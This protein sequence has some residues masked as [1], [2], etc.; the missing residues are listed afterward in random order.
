M[1]AFGLLFMVVTIIALVIDYGHK[2]VVH[3]TLDGQVLYVEFW[4]HGHMV[5]KSPFFIKGYSGTYD[6]VVGPTRATLEAMEE[7]KAGRVP[8]AN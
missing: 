4:E 8:Q 3:Q 1:K 6:T 2:P 7:V 5:K